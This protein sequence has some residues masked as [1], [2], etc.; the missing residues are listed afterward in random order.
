M[1]I[2]AFKKIIGYFNFHTDEG[3]EIKV[4]R[5]WRIILCGFIFILIIVFSLNAY[6]FRKYEK[7]LSGEVKTK[8]EKAIT[9]DRDSLQKVV[10]EI[11]RKEQQYKENLVPPQIKDPSL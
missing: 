3:R 2:V 11:E 9:I 1:K 10:E 6:I 8:E 7:G 5:D 4:L